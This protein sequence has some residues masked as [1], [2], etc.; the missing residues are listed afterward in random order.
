VIDL[1]NILNRRL[2][3]WSLSLCTK[4]LKSGDSCSLQVILLSKDISTKETAL[5]SIHLIA[6]NFTNI[7][8]DNINSQHSAKLDLQRYA[9]FIAT[10]N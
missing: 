4:L 2:A 1:L 7:I 9:N 10:A 5:D 3:A 8:F 6:K